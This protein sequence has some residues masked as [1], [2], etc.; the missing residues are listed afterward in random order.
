MKLYLD[1]CCLNRPFDDQTQSRIRL[2]AESVL[3]IMHRLEAGEWEWIGS[4]VLDFEIRQTPDRG[5]RERVRH[6]AAFVHR[7]VIV[8]ELETARAQQLES[9]GFQAFDALHLA[10]AESG[11]AD[12]FLTTDDQ[13]LRIARSVGAQLEVKVQNPLAWLREATE[14]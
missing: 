11:D 8:G 3:L 6:L 10:C 13:L 5:R 4:E 1:V 12:V 14:E 9:M 2:E 7:S